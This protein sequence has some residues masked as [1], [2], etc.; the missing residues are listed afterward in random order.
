MKE[1]KHMRYLWLI[2]RLIVPALA[3]AALLGHVKLG[4]GFST[5]R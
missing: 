4:Y 1:V 5:G 3:L 2:S